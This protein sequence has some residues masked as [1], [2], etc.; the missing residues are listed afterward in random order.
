MGA[1]AGGNGGTWGLGPFY[2][3]ILR[4]RNRKRSSGNRESKPSTSGDSFGRA[5]SSSYRFPVKQAG[6]AAS[7]V[8]T[9]DTIAQLRQRWITNRDTLSH[10][11]DSKDTLSTLLTEHDW[12]RAS[13][14]I[15][16]GFLLYGPGSFAWYQ[17]LDSC[18][19]KKSIQNLITKVLLNQV[20]LGPC[21]IAVIFAWSKLW[22]GKLADLPNKYKKD[23]LPTLFTGFRFW[24][25][26]SVLNFGYVNFSSAPHPPI[27][28]HQSNI[29]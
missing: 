1:T 3:G 6:T 8:F 28:T 7:L 21:V 4:R 23:A 13:R 22:E 24:I 5:A 26:V 10:S 17:F 25:P 29:E 19:P 14:M 15:S 12:L 11:Q 20:V 2:D 16:Y 18:L 27:S 9:G